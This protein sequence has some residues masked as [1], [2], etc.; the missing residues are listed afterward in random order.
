VRSPPESRPLLPAAPREINTP[1]NSTATHST[2]NARHPCAHIPVHARA[3]AQERGQDDPPRDQHRHQPLRAQGHQPTAGVPPSPAG[4]HACSARS[5]QSALPLTGAH[6][7]H[8]HARHPLP[9]LHQLCAR[10]EARRPPRDATCARHQHVQTR[11]LA[12]FA[13]G[14]RV[15]PPV[16]AAAAACGRARR[17]PRP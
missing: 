1:H 17:P 15:A 9:R 2:P 13:D 4:S 5:F 11:R 14:L 16:Q 12:C 7:A 6:A 10:R 8:A 3:A